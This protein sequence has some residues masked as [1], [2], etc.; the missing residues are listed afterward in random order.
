[1]DKE[2]KNRRQVGKVGIILQYANVWKW[3]DMHLKFIRYVSNIIQ[4]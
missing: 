2:V 4:E 3:D 1:M